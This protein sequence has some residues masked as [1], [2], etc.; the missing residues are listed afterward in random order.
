C[1]GRGN[2]PRGAILRRVRSPLQRRKLPAAKDLGASG[3]SNRDVKA[4][5]SRVRRMKSQKGWVEGEDAAA[6][7]KGARDMGASPGA[8]GY[9]LEDVLSGKSK[10]EV[11]VFADANFADLADDAEKVAALRKW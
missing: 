9:G 10:P 2:G 4:D 1:D 8:G 11:I 3:V 6:N 7:L 5:R